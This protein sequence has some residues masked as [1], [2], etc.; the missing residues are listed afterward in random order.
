MYRKL[1]TRTRPLSTIGRY[2][3][4]PCFGTTSC[5]LYDATLL[6]LPPWM[7]QAIGS[8]FKRNKMKMWYVCVWECK[9]LI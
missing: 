5:S 9:T 2:F 7:T 1:I 8:C 6:S 3:G 4:L